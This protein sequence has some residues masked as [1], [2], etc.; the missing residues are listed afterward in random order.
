LE[1]ILEAV[2]RKMP[3]LA[4]VEDFFP[5]IK[6]IRG[7]LSQKEFAKILGVNQTTVCKYESG[8]LPDEGTLKK[9]ADYG[10]VT[11][12]WLLRGEEKPP[13]QVLYQA[14]EQYDG[15]P[16]RPLETELLTQVVAAVEQLLA[17]RRLKLTPPQKGRLI[18]LLYEHC[19]DNRDRP[20][21]RLVEKYLLLAD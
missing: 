6:K 15:Q 18:A 4:L 5:R 17:G 20:T 19:R 3:Y 1:Y 2:K 9:I 14:P 13:H 16:L 21:L 12:E 10:G 11:V 8:R 7:D